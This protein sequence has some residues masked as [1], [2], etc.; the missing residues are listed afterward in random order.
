MNQNHFKP[1]PEQLKEIILATNGMIFSV[2]FIK[3]DG[4]LRD[5]TCRLGVQKNLV[6]GDNTVSHLDKYVTV[7][8]MA[9]DG[10]RHVDTTRIQKFKC[11]SLEYDLTDV[12][13]V[14]AS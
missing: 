1:T 3:K 13:N 9:A 12:S 5:M 10:Y 2:Q 14:K 6:G 8:D 11:K 7:Y 4:T